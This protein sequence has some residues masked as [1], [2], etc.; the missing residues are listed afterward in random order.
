[1]YQGNPGFVDPGLGGFLATRLDY[2]A[3]A[4]ANM[5][6]H[7]VPT[8]RNVALAPEGVTKAYGHNGYFKTLAGIVNFYNTRDVRPT[9]PGAYTELDALAAGCWPAPEVLANVNTAELG[10][11]GLSPDEEA[12]IVAFLKALSDGYQP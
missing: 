10:N 12:A 4:D 8:L 9:C 11:L 1:M 7:K 6:K 2:A 3:Y 5:G